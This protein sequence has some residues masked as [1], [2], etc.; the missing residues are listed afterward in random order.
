[1]HQNH[2]GGRALQSRFGGALVERAQ[3][4]SRGRSVSESCSARAGAAFIPASFWALWTKMRTLKSLKQGRHFSGTLGVRA[5]HR[6]NANV[7]DE[8][9][10][11]SRNAQPP[12]DFGHFSPARLAHY[13]SNAFGLVARKLRSIFGDARF[14]MTKQEI[15]DLPLCQ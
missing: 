7:L 6:D 13:F 11:V 5:Q 3:A 4:Q 14:G 8:P 9:T 15:Y 10:H 1:M 2:C 12:S